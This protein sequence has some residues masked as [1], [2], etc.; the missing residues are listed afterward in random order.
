[1]GWTRWRPHK[2][3][4]TLA[5]VDQYDLPERLPSNEISEDNKHRFL[6]QRRYGMRQR[7]YELEALRPMCFRTFFVR[8]SCRSRMCPPTTA[9]FGG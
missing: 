6:F 2:A 7:P 3:A 5:Q 9:G 1:M 4:L 8:P